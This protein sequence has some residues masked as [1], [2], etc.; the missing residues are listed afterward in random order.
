MIEERLCLEV[1]AINCNAVDSF[2][3]HVEGREKM[4]FIKLLFRLMTIKSCGE[5]FLSSL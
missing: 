5:I 4:R 1:F 3:K 2:L